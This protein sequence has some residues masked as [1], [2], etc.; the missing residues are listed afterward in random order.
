MQAALYYEHGHCHCHHID[1]SDDHGSPTLIVWIQVFVD[2][3]PSHKTAET[4]PKEIDDAKAE[5][6]GDMGV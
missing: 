5:K 4:G 6:T 3:L 1:D 2:I